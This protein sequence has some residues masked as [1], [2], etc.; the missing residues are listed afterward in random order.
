V[1]CDF[2]VR[3]SGITWVIPLQVPSAGCP[4]AN[5]MAGLMEPTRE[6]TE[7]KRNGWRN[8]SI[9]SISC[10]GNASEVR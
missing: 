3:I 1:S 2:D 4:L 9:A 7:K 10:V 6:K 5:E 8:G